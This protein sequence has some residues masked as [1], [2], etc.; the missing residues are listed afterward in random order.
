MAFPSD[1]DFDIVFLCRRIKRK[2]KFKCK[3]KKF[4]QAISLVKIEEQFLTWNKF[5]KRQNFQ[6]KFDK[7]ECKELFFWENFNFWRQSFIELL[8][9]FT[10]WLTFFREQRK[11]RSCSKTKDNANHNLKRKFFFFYFCRLCYANAVDQ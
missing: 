3:T 11:R 2:Q 9:R 1:S 6:L 5:N 8:T 10:R 7:N 4:S